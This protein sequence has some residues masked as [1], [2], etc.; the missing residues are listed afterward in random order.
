LSSHGKTIGFDRELHLSWLDAIAAKAAERTDTATAR[1]WLDNYLADSLK[2]DKHGGARYKTKTVL[3]RIWISPPESCRTLH[4][5]ALKLL[6]VVDPPDRVAIHWGLA[7]AVYPFLGDVADTVGRLIALHGDVQRTSVV[8]RM[9][10]RWGERQF[11]N[12]ATRAVW[13]S[14][15]LWGGLRKT[16]VAGRCLPSTPPKRVTGN[17]QAFLIESLLFWSNGK[18]IIVPSIAAHPVLFPFDMSDA[19]TIARTSDRLSV[20]REGGNLEVVSMRSATPT[21]L[22][23]VK[24]K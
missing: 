23:D 19:S 3:C 9:Y 6:P 15:I 5:L 21:L 16:E 12:R 14:F 22:S 17:L 11:V 8:R 7:C 24:T 13:N 18:P 2:D 20:R 10:E 4:D 1:A